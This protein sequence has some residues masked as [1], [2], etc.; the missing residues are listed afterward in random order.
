MTHGNL[1]ELRF[2]VVLLLL[3]VSAVAG[4]CSVKQ[5]SDNQRA[6]NPSSGSDSGH[7]AEALTDQD[8]SVYSAILK[9]LLTK[10]KLKFI[11]IEDHTF[12]YKPEYSAH[13]T[14]FGNLGLYFPDSD[15]EA[16][17][18][19]V[20][21]NRYP[22][23]LGY[24]LD[25]PVKYGFVSHE[26][27]EKD[28]DNVTSHKTKGTFYDRFPDADGVLAFSRIGFNAHFNQAIVEV[29]RSLCRKGCFSMKYVFLTREGQT[30]AVKRIEDILRA[31][32]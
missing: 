6:S 30:W 15:V 8:Y 25:I 2:L 1:I 24:S 22:L 3:N 17:R 4:A 7:R 19:Y 13:D 26:E 29:A 27:V 32:L 12:V 10:E 23:P 5:A 14:T 16:R 18:N 9:D 21:Q 31:Y 20:E 28:Y 11:V